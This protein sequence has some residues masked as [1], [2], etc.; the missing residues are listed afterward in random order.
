M[1]FAGI[2][3]SNGMGAESSERKMAASD[4]ELAKEIIVEIIRQSG[5]VLD[6]TTAIFK[7]FY[8]AAIKFGKD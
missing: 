7:A 3:S 2:F 6:L 1:L 5:G 8:H 4:K